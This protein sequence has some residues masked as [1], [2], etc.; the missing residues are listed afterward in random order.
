MQHRNLRAALEANAIQ[1]LQQAVDHKPL[2]KKERSDFPMVMS[3]LTDP[4]TREQFNVSLEDLQNDKARKIFKG[5]DYKDLSDD[6]KSRVDKVIEDIKGKMFKAFACES[7]E[8]KT[9]LKLFLE[10]N[11]PQGVIGKFLFADAFKSQFASREEELKREFED[12]E[13][14]YAYGHKF[15]DFQKIHAAINFAD[16]VV[17]GNIP[18]ETPERAYKAMAIFWE[19]DATQTA[20]NINEFIKAFT[21]KY[22][23]PIHD[24]FMDQL[25]TGIKQAE[26]LKLMKKS[27][28]EVLKEVPRAL[29]IEQDENALKDIGKF[30]EKVKSLKYSRQKENPELAELY[31]FYEVDNETFELTLDL[32]KEGE[33]LASLKKLDNLPSVEHKLEGT[34]KNLWLMKLP[35]GDPRGL[36]LGKI[37]NCCQSINGHSEECVIDGMTR[38][39]NGFYVLVELPKGKEPKDIKWESFEKDGNKIL[40][41]GYAWKSKTGNLTFDSWENLNPNA[42]DIDVARNLV[43]FTDKLIEADPSISRVTLGLG[44]KTPAVLKQLIEST[45]TEDI[46]EG[47]FYGDSRQQIEIGACQELEK[48]RGQIREVFPESNLNITTIAQAKYILEHREEFKAIDPAE[49]WIYSSWSIVLGEEHIK[50][51]V[52]EISDDPLSLMLRDEAKKGYRTEKVSARDLKDLDPEKIKLLIS[53]RAIKAYNTGKV[54]AQDLKDLPQEKI[55]LLI[56]DEAICAYQT[57]RVRAQNLVRLADQKILEILCLSIMTT[58]TTHKD[59]TI[60]F[61]EGVEPK[62]LKLIVSDD[63]IKLYETGQVHP[64]DLKSLSVA[65]IKVLTSE[66]AIDIFQTHNVN[67]KAIQKYTASELEY[68]FSEQ[69]TKEYEYIMYSGSKLGKVMDAILCK[70]KSYNNKFLSTASDVISTVLALPKLPKV[71]SKVSF[72]SHIK[73]AETRENQSNK[74]RE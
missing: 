60:K 36:I 1:T 58:Y 14:R 8:A 69:F 50:T 51:L 11:E 5:K 56:S 47:Y 16:Q 37:T 3:Y 35:A 6:E 38:P 49:Q 59:L 45:E 54:S 40:G 27:G 61:F 13:Q 34:A 64:R 18:S 7:D 66:N 21:S 24:M 39:N 41:Q 63:A 22:P 68:F 33:P 55:D 48:L 4:K 74:G 9:K 25:P 20:K 12:L 42:N 32:M 72:D 44:G 17:E 71:T 70:A 2:V 52:N 57:G 30:R 23:N 53:Y 46:Q 19:K 43:A 15:E 62:K 31:S 29:E 65:Q 73:K 67:F 28:L 10:E 26:W